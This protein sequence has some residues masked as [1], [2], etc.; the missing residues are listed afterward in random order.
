MRD[1]KTTRYV[2][3]FYTIELAKEKII[4]GVYMSDSL[5]DKVNR[6]CGLARRS[7]WGLEEDIEV[8]IGIEYDFNHN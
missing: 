7:I 5:K 2:L 6:L 3:D 4:E 8:N 1:K